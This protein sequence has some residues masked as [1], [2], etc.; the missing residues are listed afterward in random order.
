MVNHGGVSPACPDPESGGGTLVLDIQEPA[1][2]VK[3]PTRRPD[4]DRLDELREGGVLE[5][6]TPSDTWQLEVEVADAEF[7]VIVWQQVSPDYRDAYPEKDGRAWVVFGRASVWCWYDARSWL[8]SVLAS[9]MLA[10]ATAV[11]REGACLTE[12]EP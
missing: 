4:L 3:G 7:D 5:L 1:P 8:T 2:G 6:A 12:D 11:R 9:M 10:S